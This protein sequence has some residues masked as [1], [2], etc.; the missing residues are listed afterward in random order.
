MPPGRDKSQTGTMSELLKNLRTLID[1]AE[2]DKAANPLF[3]KDLRTLA[4]QYGPVVGWPVKLLYDDFQD[5]QYTSNPAWSVMA[6][7]WQ[8]GNVGSSP[9]L[10]S[11]VRLPNASGQS[12]NNG[13]RPAPQCPGRGR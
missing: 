7:Q 8:V 13:G 11:Q 2:R 9:A 12:S 5:G 3:L 4:D 6:G 1:K 10:F